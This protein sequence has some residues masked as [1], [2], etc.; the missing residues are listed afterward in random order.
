M[1]PGS[2]LSL[3]G[4][5]DACGLST[6]P[7]EDVFVPE[8]KRI[9]LAQTA[10]WRPWTTDGAARMGGYVI[11]WEGGAARFVSIRG[12]GHMSPLNRPNATFT[13]ID[14]FTGGGGKLPDALP[15][16]KAPGRALRTLYL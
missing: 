10:E 15:S 2:R 9:G 11:E 14:A 3:E 5:N 16:F 4:D 8:F 7:I 6:A 1:R 13:M 12:A